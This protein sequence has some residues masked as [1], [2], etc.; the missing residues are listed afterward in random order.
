MNYLRIDTNDFY[1]VAYHVSE[2]LK[3]KFVSNESDKKEKN[4]LYLEIAKVLHKPAVK[5]AI[6]YAFPLFCEIFTKLIITPTSDLIIPPDEYELIERD[7]IDKFKKL[8]ADKATESNDLYYYLYLSIEHNS[9]E[10][11]KYLVGKIEFKTNDLDK[12]IKETLKLNSIDILKIIKANFEIDKNKALEILDDLVYF[13]NDYNTA[14]K[15]IRIFKIDFN[16]YL[17]EFDIN[18]SE[19]SLANIR[20]IVKKYSEYKSLPARHYEKLGMQDFLADISKNSIAKNNNNLI[21]YMIHTKDKDDD[22][23]CDNIESDSN[24]SN[25]QCKIR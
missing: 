11:F 16:T 20:E 3:S 12:L 13:S 6:V 18:K 1:R 23:A 21:T 7:D 10:I 9:S 4:D 8:V 19:Q 14:Y 25:Q 15:V 22:E 17:E 5:I 24:S 2:Y